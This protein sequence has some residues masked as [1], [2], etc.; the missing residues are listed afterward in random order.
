MPA[1]KPIITGT[2][3]GRLTVE[4]H[5]GA[6]CACVCACGKR[7][8][9]AARD[10]RTGQTRSCGCLSRE[11][12]AERMRLRK[13]KHGQNRKGFRT[14]TYRSWESM[15]SRCHRARD[16]MFQYYGGRGITVC[17]RWTSF[18]AF[19]SDMGERPPGMT[20]DRIDPDGHYEPGNCRW[21]TK[22]QQARNRRDSRIDDVIA[23]QIRWL[24]GDAGFRRGDIA[25]AFGLG[26]AF[27]NSVARGALWQE[28][29][30]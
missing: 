10:L 17:E 9:V 24:A 19:A 1:R 16:P 4:T 14:P 8:T 23:S 13:I 30:G 27:I 3:F 2:A 29:P 7:V 26:V 28:V 12:S 22:A 18:E 6:R 21:A 5:E 25:R 15:R 11:L 20:L